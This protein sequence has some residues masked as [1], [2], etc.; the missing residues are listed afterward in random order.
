MSDLTDLAAHELALTLRQ[1]KASSREMM[2]ACL[3]RIVALNRRYNAIVS[4]RDEGELLR[5]ADR[6][7]DV[8]ARRDPNA[9]PLPFLFGLPQAIKDVVPTAGIRT[10]FGSPLLRDFVPSADALMV[11]RMKAAGCIVIGKTNTPEFGLGSH[12][13]NEVFGATATP[14][15]RRDR[16]AAA[17]AVRRSR[18]RRGCCRSPT[19]ATRWAA[20]ATRPP[21]TTSSASGRARAGCRRRRRRTCG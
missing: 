4:L 8:L 21:G 6:C 1:K 14:T 9:A 17:A 2:S 5:E 3:A 15:I 16:R 11:R 20:C 12:T 10:T 18:W 19:A 7:D 13:F